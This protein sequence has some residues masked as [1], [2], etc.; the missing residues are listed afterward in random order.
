[1]GL[2]MSHLIGGS[3]DA[4]SHQN[5]PT[6]RAS[7]GASWWSFARRHRKLVSYHVDSHREDHRATLSVLQTAAAATPRST[8]CINRKLCSLLALCLLIASHSHLRLVVLK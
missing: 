7:D 8:V 5:G 4:E 2:N 1:M 3:P 6:R